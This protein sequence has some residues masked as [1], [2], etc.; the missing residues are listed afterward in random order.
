MW[1][2]PKRCGEV[3]GVGKVEDQKDAFM[4][5]IRRHA[6]TPQGAGGF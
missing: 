6:S 5:F 4:A 2:S 1:L 3:G